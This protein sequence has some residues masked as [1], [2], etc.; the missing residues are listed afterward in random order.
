M[1]DKILELHTIPD[2]HKDTNLGK[3]QVLPVKMALNDNIE[4]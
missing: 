3:K 4:Y 2:I 1:L